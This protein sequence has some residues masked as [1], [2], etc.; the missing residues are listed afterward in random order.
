LFQFPSWSATLGCI[1]VTGW[2][3]LS[4]LLLPVL[5]ASVPGSPAPWLRPEVT[6]LLGQG[7]PVGGLR[8][9]GSDLP[10]SWLRGA[11]VQNSEP[12][13]GDKKPGPITLQLVVQR[14]ETRGAWKGHPSVH[15]RCRTISEP[16]PVCAKY[17]FQSKRKCLQKE[18][19]IAFFSLVLCCQVTEC[20]PH[21]C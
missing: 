15:S 20:F 9:S 8:L 6:F 5:A 11:R 12:V 7:L 17:H 10:L 18:P 4:P 14:R 2:D 19:T 1:T 16:P 21:L 13:L 3:P